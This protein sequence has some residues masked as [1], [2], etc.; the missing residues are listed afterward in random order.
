MGVSVSVRAMGDG[1]E[2]NTEGEGVALGR[3]LGCGQIRVRRGR[4]TWT[5]FPSGFEQESS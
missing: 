5:R 1:I 2:E 3:R 4:E